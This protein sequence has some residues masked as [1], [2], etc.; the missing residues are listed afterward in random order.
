MKTV[1]L[2]SAS[3]VKRR[4]FEELLG[5]HGM[6]VE[7][8]DVPMNEVQDVD[9][10]VVSRLKA[11]EAARLTGLR[12][13]LVDDTGLE[14][15]DL[16]GA[17][18]ALLKPLLTH[19]GVALIDRMCRSYQTNGM[20]PARYVCAIT[21]VETDRTIEVF[22]D[23]SGVLDFAGAGPVSAEVRDCSGLFRATAAGPTLLEHAADVGSAAYL[24]RASA[25]NA[26]VGQLS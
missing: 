9:V 20:C 23:M 26:L 5:G 2:V 17:P 18:G 21:M 10:R 19:G 6:D 14:F 8:I 1:Y 12:P 16:M 4:N 25:V 22:G 24:H 3:K 15:P 11:A 7:S 13:L